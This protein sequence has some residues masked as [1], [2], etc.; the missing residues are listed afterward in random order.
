MSTVHEKVESPPK[1]HS[2]KECFSRVFIESRL[3]AYR[4]W[5]HSKGS[6]ISDIHYRIWSK[7]LLF[8]CL[9]SKGA[10]TRAISIA[11]Y[12]VC[13]V[14]TDGVGAVSKV[15]TMIEETLSKF[16]IYRTNRL[17]SIFAPSSVNIVQYLLSC[18]S[19][20]MAGTSIQMLFQQTQSVEYQKVF[21]WREWNFLWQC[22]IFG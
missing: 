8:Y 13:A 7:F 2:L 21:G 20:A 9:L 18:R 3:I 12:R 6:K 4:N 10:L 19:V 17:P 1:C 15:C 14:R 16:E 5:L 11:R 22:L